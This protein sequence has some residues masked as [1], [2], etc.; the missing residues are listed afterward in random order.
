MVISLRRHRPI[1]SC[2]DE[3]IRFHEHEYRWSRTVHPSTLKPSAFKFKST[4]QKPSKSA[5]LNTQI[6]QA[7]HSPSNHSV[8]IKL[9]DLESEKLLE[10]VSYEINTIRQLRHPNLLP[11]LC[12][13]VVE[14]HLWNVITSAQYGS[15]NLWSKPNG[16]PELAIAFII[17]DVLLALDYLHKRGI[18]H[19]AVCGSHI[20]INSKGNCMLTGLKYSTSVLKDGRWHSTIH[21]YP[22][23]SIK[24][25]NHLAPEIL[26]QNLLGYNS[27][28][29]IYSLGIVCCELAN[30][31]VPYEDIA[32]TEM[33]LDKL[34]GNFPRPLDSTCDEIRNFPTD[35][36][37]LSPEVREKY[38]TYRN[39]TFSQSFHKFTNENCLTFD[40]YT[41]PTA[42]TLL[43]HSFIKQIKKSNTNLLELLQVNSTKQN[44]MDTKQNESIDETAIDLG[45]KLVLEDNGDGDDIQWMF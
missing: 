31:C 16:I 20:L 17:R 25:A 37:D 13:F 27:K 40:S 19:R 2:S 34:T 33:L 14:N 21:E 7:N 26:E 3:L 28:S 24:I 41:R 10:Y 11:L 9:V 23:N 32:L 4:I 12:S 18:I 43:S 29:D 38:E 36:E 39:R 35:I 8:V 15:T 30:G 45:R 1:F 44:N 6:F 42:S 22:K 5:N